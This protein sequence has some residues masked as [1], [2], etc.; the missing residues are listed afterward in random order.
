LLKLFKG[1]RVLLGVKEPRTSRSAEL[2]RD[3]GVRRARL[4]AVEGAFRHVHEHGKRP[5]GAAPNLVE[6]CAIVTAFRG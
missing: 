5:P 1:G 6:K 3:A 2:G 4:R